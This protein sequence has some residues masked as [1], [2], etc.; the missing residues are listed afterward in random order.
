MRS[1]LLPPGCK[2]IALWISISIVLLISSSC[3]F[4]LT[5]DSNKIK[6]A[7]S[8][9]KSPKKIL[10][11]HLLPSSR[12]KPGQKLCL[13]KDANDSDNT[14]TQY[15]DPLHYKFSPAFNDESNEEEEEKEKTKIPVRF[16]NVPP[17]IN[18]GKDIVTVGNLN[19]NLLFLAEKAGLNIPRACRTGLCGTC[20]ADVQDPNFVGEDE[21]SDSKDGGDEKNNSEPSSGETTGVFGY[22]G[23]TGWQIVR[24]CT[25]N[26]MLLPGTEEMVVDV[27]RMRRKKKKSK[28]SNPSVVSE[29]N[30]EA[31]EMK[32]ESITNPMERFS[33]DWEREFRPDYKEGGWQKTQKNPSSPKNSGGKCPKCNGTGVIPCYS[34]EGKGFVMQSSGVK[35]QC[36]LCMGRGVTN[37]AYC[38]GKGTL[39]NKRTTF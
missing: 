24:T 37:C 15:S 3:A 10:N 2:R 34:C 38:Q 1:V 18:D 39:S 4:V 9:S 21:T 29:A 8:I 14:S 31:D 7:S 22:T 19:E 6:H 36:F 28:K 17:H 16:I 30:E 35:Q 13:S 26:V 5:Y 23:R 25:T 20:T 32:E 27:H 12:S 33:G 11:E